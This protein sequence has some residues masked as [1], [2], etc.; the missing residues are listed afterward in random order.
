MAGLSSAGLCG[1]LSKFLD[2]GNNNE[3]YEDGGSFLKPNKYFMIPRVYCFV[4]F[5]NAG[6]IDPQN[7]PMSMEFDS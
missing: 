3:T 7:F 1:R 2:Y 5:R 4:D 6:V